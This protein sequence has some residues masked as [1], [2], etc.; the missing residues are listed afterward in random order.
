MEAISSKR[1]VSIFAE[2]KKSVAI[3]P[4]CRRYRQ[5]RN[6]AEIGDRFHRRV[7]DVGLAG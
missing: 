1:R 2:S 5:D 3:L 6:P 4:D 7:R